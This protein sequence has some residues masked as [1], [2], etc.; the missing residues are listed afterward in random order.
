M[1]KKIRTIPEVNTFTGIIDNLYFERTGNLREKVG[2]L[3]KE[4]LLD[5]TMYLIAGLDELD[6]QLE[7]V[8][9]ILNKA[10]GYCL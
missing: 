7:K 4:E 8:Q 1:S 9:S 10:T 5:F 2:E 6:T 3:S